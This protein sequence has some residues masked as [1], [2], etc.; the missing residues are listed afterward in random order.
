MREHSGQGNSNIGKGDNTLWDPFERLDNHQREQLQQFEQLLVAY[1]QKINVISQGTEAYFAERHILHALCI[2]YKSFP[3]GSTVVDWGSGGG[4]P[5]IPLA[6]RFP[7]V[8]FYAVDAVRKK[9][10]VVT[11]IARRL[12]LENLA[13]WH[14]RAASWPGQADFAVS[15]A[16]APLAV[17]WEWFNRVCNPDTSATQNDSTSW[18]PGL[19]VLKGGNLDSEIEA[20]QRT[21][22]GTSLTSYDLECLL[23]RAYFHRKRLLHITTSRNRGICT[24][25]N[26]P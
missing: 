20:L 23:G 3:A 11:A 13:T 17:L 5:A 24:N 15:R 12:S 9:L 14:G 22:P 18:E 1:N 19:I 4:L 26:R 8:Q 2:A 25:R 16:T 21:A 7:Q 6:I 10:Q